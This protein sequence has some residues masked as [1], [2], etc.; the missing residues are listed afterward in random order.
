MAKRIQL[1][2]NMAEQFPV[3][4]SLIQILNVG[5]VR[6]PSFKRSISATRSGIK[7][8]S[9]MHPP[10]LFLK[11]GNIASRCQLLPDVTLRRVL[12]VDWLI[13]SRRIADL[14]GARI[15]V[16]DC[17][18]GGMYRGQ[19]IAAPAQ[20]VSVKARRVLTERPR[21]YRLWFATRRAKRSSKSVN[22]RR[23]S[24]V[25]NFMDHVRI[26][27]TSDPRRSRP[28]GNHGKRREIVLVADGDIEA[29]QLH[30]DKRFFG[31]HVNPGSNPDD[32]IEVENL[33]G[34]QFK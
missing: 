32:P 8:R 3:A 23:L 6:Y 33:T 17:A 26:T 29:A 1:D 5:S 34:L 16:D 12:G 11:P 25:R 31:C 28:F 15:A 19:T 21:P 20:R 10:R 24:E 9:F 7:P 27:R 18:L 22:R 13:V 14:A 4:V 30:I 2:F